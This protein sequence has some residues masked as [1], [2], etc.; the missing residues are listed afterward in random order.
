MLVPTDLG[1]SDSGANAA[2]LEGAHAVVV[3]HGDPVV[4]PWIFDLARMTR[5]WLVV[6]DPAPGCYQHLPPEAEVIVNAQPRGFAANVNAAFRQAA[7]GATALLCANFDVDLSLDSLQLLARALRE[8]PDAAVAAPLLTDQQGAPVFSAGSLPTPAKELLRAIGLRGPA[9]MRLQRVVLRRRRTWRERNSAAICRVLGA[10]EYLPWTVI[11]VSVPAWEAL[12]PLDERFE[13][14]AEDLDWGLR[15]AEAGWAA[16]L[17]DAGRVVHTERATRSPTTTAVYERSHQAL[18]AKYGWNGPARWQARGL[19]WRRWTP[20]RWT[21]AR[22]DWDVVDGR[23]G[24][25][26]HTPP[27]ISP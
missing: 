20:L 11:A 25:H 26:P 3:L 14:Y 6:N 23:R 5:L 2:A 7:P 15:A 27:I 12:G 24:L 19:A 10:G 9:A 21:T 18:H 13:L 17:I 1:A 22:L 16:L 4:P 8:R